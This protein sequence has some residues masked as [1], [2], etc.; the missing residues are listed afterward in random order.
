MVAI[1]ATKVKAARDNSALGN[2]GQRRLSELNDTFLISSLPVTP[3]IIGK[4]IVG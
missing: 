4:A 3:K 1:F 2:N